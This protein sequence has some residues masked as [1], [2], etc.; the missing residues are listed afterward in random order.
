VASDRYDISAK[1][2]GEITPL[3]RGPMALSLLE[4]GFRL[5][6]HHEAKDEQGIALTTGKFFHPA[7]STE[8]LGDRQSVGRRRI[9]DGPHVPKSLR[10]VLCESTLVQPHKVVRL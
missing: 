3:E 8:G 9:R 1:A 5:A 10:S 7:M 6:V 2:D 4:D